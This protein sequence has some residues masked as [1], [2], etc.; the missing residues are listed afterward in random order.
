VVVAV[1]ASSAQLPIV[2]DT[3]AITALLQR[4]LNNVLLRPMNLRIVQSF[5]QLGYACMQMGIPGSTRVDNQH[6]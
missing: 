3:V 2:L 4:A 1:V 5:L 6:A